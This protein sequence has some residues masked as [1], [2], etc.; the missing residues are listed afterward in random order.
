VTES[1][2]GKFAS[3]GKASSRY[4]R[5]T[6]VN[7]RSPCCEKVKFPLNGDGSDSGSGTP[8][9]KTSAIQSVVPGTSV[10]L[11]H[12]RPPCWQF[13]NSF[14]SRLTAYQAS[15]TWPAAELFPGSHVLTRLSTSGSDAPDCFQVPSMAVPSALSLPS[16]V[17][18]PLCISKCKSCPFMFIEP[19]EGR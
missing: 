4:E 11:F 7:T 13:F 18:A 9:H 19:G 6:A 14:S 8:F 3:N 12:C 2:D 17:L 16:Y 10:S 15:A 1:Q 5:V